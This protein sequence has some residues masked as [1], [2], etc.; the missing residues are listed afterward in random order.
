MT[1]DGGHAPAAAPGPQAPPASGAAAPG[2]GA[3]EK[4]AEAP[5]EARPTDSALADRM[6][7]ALESHRDA[8]GGRPYVGDIGR[9]MAEG[10]KHVTARYTDLV[11]DAGLDDEFAADPD[12]VLRAAARAARD[13]LARAHP[14]YAE[15]VGGELSVRVT[16]FPLR[17]T[18]REINSDNAGRFV[19][20]RAMVIRMSVAESIPAVA[21]YACADGHET[22]VKAG[23]N[24][25]LEAPVVCGDPGC[26][27]RDLE[28]IPQKSRFVDYQILQLQE[29][30]GELP[31]GSLPKTLGVFVSGSLVDSARMGDTVEIGGVIR[32][33]LSREIKLGVP[34]QT[35]RHRLYANSIERVAGEDDRGGRITGED[36]ERITAMVRGAHAGDEDDATAM[37]V[38][39]FAPHIH[40]NRLVREALVLTVIGSDEQALSDGTR[41]RGDI[42]TF[43]VGDPGTGKS[44]M[45]KAAHRVAPR[46][47]YTSGRGSSGAGLT[48]ATIKDNV[49]GAY[50]LEPGITVLADRGLAVI[51]EF[52]KMKPE[53]RSVLHE[54]M[55]QQ[56][57]SI[58]KGGITA[59]LNARTSIIAIANPVY[60]RY[61]PFRNLT[62]NIPSIPIPLLTRFDMIFV[63]RDVPSRDRDRTVG[64]HIIATRGGGDPGGRA[65]MDTDTFRK[66]L[67]LARR[68]RPKLSRRAE[69]RILEYYVRVRNAGADGG[70]AEPGLAITPRQLE[71]L[72]RLTVARA[73]MLLKDEADEAD[74]ER[75]VYILEEM[76]RSSGIDVNTGK[77]DTGVLQGAP[78][79]EA[80]KIALF[81][82]LVKSLTEDSPRGTTWKELAGEMEKTGKWDEAS[83]N[84]FIRKAVAGSIVY[85]SSPGRYKAVSGT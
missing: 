63:V 58:A 53:D 37:V 24:M 26:K 48:A 36:A 9:M 7:E 47:F 2:G 50:M 39:S 42:N 31:A 19:A 49:T 45:G 6:R 46:A 32:P 29:L 21:A 70:P 33:E 5:A 80:G 1:P 79:S 43:L 71:G 14:E 11:F 57:A 3:G 76:F 40:G 60:G 82:D 8:G 55:E 81:Q 59:T 61:D 74:A 16:G 12:R 72:V 66:Y 77:V 78:R 54:V 13:I 4:G 20:V 23:S 10:R 41:V 65:A 18:V 83:A 56:T 85:E 75:A 28:L 44:E 73:R 30:P 25:A 27:H 51:D 69:E 67:R 62:E 34:V 22:T 38:D 35:Y 17:H 52:D 64:G 15:H 68:K 84:E